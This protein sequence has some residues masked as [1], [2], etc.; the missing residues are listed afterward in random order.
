MAL[1]TGPQVGDLFASVEDGA[2]G[3]LLAAVDKVAC[4]FFAYGFESRRNEAMNE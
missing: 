1:L 4:K 2:S 3:T